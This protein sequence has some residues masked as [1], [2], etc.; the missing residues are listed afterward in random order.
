MN[1][2]IYSVDVSSDTCIEVVFFDGAVKEYDVK[3]L[4][5]YDKKYADLLRNKKLYENVN[6]SDNR[7]GIKWGDSVDY[8]VDS[9]TLY[10]EGILV[11]KKFI[12]D[13]KVQLAHR[14]TKIREH[15]G[16][17]QKE[18][19]KKTGIH[20]ADISKIE[21]GIANPS[22]ET[23]TRL[24]DAMNY[25][26]N[27]DFVKKNTDEGEFVRE[28]VV[29]NLVSWKSQG[30]Y[31]VDDIM[32]LPEWVR[33]E[34]I[35]GVLYDMAPPNVPHQR[36]VFDFA[37]KVRRFIEARKGACEVFISPIGVLIS[38]DD[39]K[40]YLEPDMV[41][42]C[43]PDKIT[44]NFIISPDFVLEV[45]SPSTGARDFAEKKEKYRKMGVKEYWIVDT[46][47]KRLVVYLADD[48]FNIPQIHSLNEEVG[49][50]MY[51]NE[52]K[53]DLSEF[54]ECLIDDKK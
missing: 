2:R 50:H 5:E 48:G 51:N 16:M 34:L 10:Y 26:V 40:N 42:V 18:L 46:R 35:D 33:A 13:A 30:E 27:Y 29:R 20:Q 31:T 8:Y 45:T 53:L 12:G 21:R 38:R 32:S 24:A 22:I 19:E 39:N 25:S 49:I 37:Y 9:E 41:I 1:H 7:C 14:L 23:I 52:L 47:R 4:S 36:I 11:E 44:R 43:D 6:V 17:T 54:G 3:R 28:S 15:L